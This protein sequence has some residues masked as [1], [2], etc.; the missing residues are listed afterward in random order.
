MRASSKAALMIAT[1]VISLI[2]AIFAGEFNDVVE[3]MQ[4]LS[5][6]CLAGTPRP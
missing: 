1:G 6:S 4:Q 3:F 5:E 2:L